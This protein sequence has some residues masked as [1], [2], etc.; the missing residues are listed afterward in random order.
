MITR[1]VIVT[2]TEAQAEA[3]VHLAQIAAS[4]PDENAGARALLVH[5][6]AAAAEI[7]KALR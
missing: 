3:L 7:Q 2:L 5:A 4:A 6:S 1:Y